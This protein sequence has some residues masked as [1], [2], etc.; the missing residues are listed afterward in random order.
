MDEYQI[1]HAT[2]YAQLERDV[3]EMCKYAWR[4]LG[5]PVV[6]VKQSPHSVAAAE[7]HFIQALIREERE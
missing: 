2:N 1:I 3:N 4:P 6:Y 7:V 5:A